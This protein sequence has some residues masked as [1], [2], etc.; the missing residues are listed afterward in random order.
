VRV[1][2]DG[3][4][5]SSVSRDKRRR[6]NDQSASQEPEA[7]QPTAVVSNLPPSIES[8]LEKVPDKEARSMLSMAVSRTSFG[9]GPDAETMKVMAET[10]VHEETCRLDAYKAALANRD[11]Q[12]E[13][14]HDFRKRKLNHQTALTVLVLVAGGLLIAF[15][16][17]IYTS[18]QNQLGGYLIVGGA[19]ILF[20]ALG[21]KP[22]TSPKE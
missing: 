2:W 17:Y 10:E 8:A 12:A 14:D 18:N 5:Q 7:K 1:S 20:H 11:K 4:G 16:I 3:N 6:S 22:P 15:G 13:R 9:F 19:A 21:I